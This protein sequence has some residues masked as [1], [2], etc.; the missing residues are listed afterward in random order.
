MRGL[1]HDLGEVPESSFAEVLQTIQAVVYE[2][3][4][5][6]GYLSYVITASP[7][8]VSFMVLEMAHDETAKALQAADFAR[9]KLFFRFLCALHPVI[10]NTDVLTSFLS[11]LVTAQPPDP[12]VK[13]ELFKVA[14]LASLY[15]PSHLISAELRD[16]FTNAELSDAVD[17]TYDYFTGDSKPY[18]TKFL[19]SLL[20]DAVKQL[21]DIDWNANILA[22]DP[23]KH[24]KNE[25][26]PEEAT[27]AEEN[28]M[29][30][31]EKNVAQDALEDSYEPQPSSEPSEEKS[32]K[33]ELVTKSDGNGDENKNPNGDSHLE[34]SRIEQDQIESPQ[35]TLR[36]LHLPDP[37][38]FRS[39]Y[40]PA[41]FRCYHPLEGQYETVPPGNTIEGILLRDITTDIMRHMDFNRREVTRQLIALDMF[42]SRTAF[43]P[44]GAWLDQI[45]VGA[46]E[47]PPKPTW[48]VEDIAL[49]AVFAQMFDL[50]NQSSFPLVYYHSLLIEACVMAPQDIAPVLGRGIRYLFGHL[51]SIDVELFFRVIDW[52]SHHVSNFAFTWKW[53][54]WVDA[55]SLPEDH[56][57]LIFIKEL[58]TKEVRLSYPQR[59]RDVLP[60]EFQPLV[61]EYPDVP[62]FKY[63]DDE[64][65]SRLVEALQSSDVDQAKDILRACSGIETEQI[66][67]LVHTICHLGNRSI[68]HAT[69][70]ITK[71]EV[72]LQ[73]LIR[74]DDNEAVNALLD[75]VYEHWA[76]AQW[77]GSLVIDQFVKAN[78]LNTE[79]LVK[80]II[81]NQNL[82]LSSLG[83]E[84]VTK[85]IEE[86]E[87]LF[88]HVDLHGTY[89]EWW[90]E[91]LSKAISRIAANKKHSEQE[92]LAPISAS[93]AGEMIS[94]ENLES[95]GSPKEQSEEA[96]LENPEELTGSS[97]DIEPSKDEASYA[98]ESDNEPE[99]PKAKRQKKV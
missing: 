28:L 75:A 70:W 40:S 80:Y 81:S 89:A 39:K 24:S 41:Y 56:P 4:H 61:P 6:I 60:E 46:K 45:V 22:A 92:P 83:W 94:A 7:S 1:V 37:L 71:S 27:L 18:E 99:G 87:K 78:H 36:P 31:G 52:F 13:T 12:R 67:Y 20:P 93:V 34:G 19:S 65:A 64:N 35:H 30:D 98:N 95:A 26:N 51:E 33:D 96:S 11:S 68:T 3:P 97:H 57:K 21:S 48:K 84:I 49:E 15:L 50:E 47:D 8:H 25:G 10:A 17:D 42:F 9:F 5:K 44:P 77:I 38:I 23:L 88:A 66:S 86:A 2:Q 90:R 72:L 79:A 29:A 55:L 14:L 58:L 62:P 43:A 53:N 76:D 16:Q 73:M 85:N 32:T 69:T 63:S 59:V 54:E 82:L 74:A 91:R